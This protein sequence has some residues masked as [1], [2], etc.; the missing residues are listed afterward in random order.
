MIGCGVM[1]RLIIR[2]RLGL[3]SLIRLCWKKRRIGWGMLVVV[4]GPLYCVI[5]FSGCCFLRRFCGIL[6]HFFL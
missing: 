2:R 3:A 1:I 5:K 4:G 6:L